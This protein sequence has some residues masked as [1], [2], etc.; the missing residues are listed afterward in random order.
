MKKLFITTILIF[1]I[2][3]ISNAQGDGKFKDDRKVVFEN[4][5]YTVTEYDS[6]PGKDVCGS[7]KHSHEGHL[8]IALT[9]AK[10]RLTSANGETK[11]IEIPEGATFW[12]DAETHMVINTGDKPAKFLLIVP[13]E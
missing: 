13:K 12:S 8:T 10:V 5:K 7:G 3:I 2:G 6:N 9:N 11:E 1:G 4:E